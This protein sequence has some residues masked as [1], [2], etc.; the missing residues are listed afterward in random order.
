MSI[1]KRGE[2]YYS[3]LRGSSDLRLVMKKTKLKKWG[4][5]Y[6]DQLI[7]PHADREPDKIS[8]ELLSKV[9]EA[10][11]KE[12]TQLSPTFKQSANG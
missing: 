9:I 6:S 8:S 2:I 10:H 1:Q 4:G 3:R 5:D 7:L 12:H 11:I